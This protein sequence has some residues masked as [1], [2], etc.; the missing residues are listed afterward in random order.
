MSIPNPNTVK[1]KKLCQCMRLLWARITQ[2]FDPIINMQL[3][4][5]VHSLYFFGKMWLM[6]G[7]SDSFICV[8]AKTYYIPFT[9][10][11]RWPPPSSIITLLQSLLDHQPTDNVPSGLMGW[12]GRA[13]LH[14]MFGPSFHPLCWT[15][16]CHSAL[17]QKVVRICWKFI[18]R[19]MINTCFTLISK[20]PSIAQ[21]VERWTVVVLT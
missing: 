5:V 7:R 15:F 6:N 8:V 14:G 10:L 1:A 12:M 13:S 17:V 16:C 4:L 2:P 9:L 21:L 3:F 18:R 19:Q 20:H 11:T